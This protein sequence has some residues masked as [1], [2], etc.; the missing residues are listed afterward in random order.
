M[1]RFDQ[2]DDDERIGEDFGQVDGDRSRR[3][4]FEPRSAGQ[5]WLRNNGMPPWHMWG[6]TQ[7]QSVQPLGGASVPL[8][9]TSQQLCRINYGRPESWRW[10]FKAKLISGP[11]TTDVGQHGSLVVHWDLI[12]GVGRSMIQLLDFD[13]FSFAWDDGE[14]FPANREIWSTQTL[15]PAK[16]FVAPT[17]GAAATQVDNITAQDIQL[18]ARCTAQELSIVPNAPIVVELSAHFAPNAH[19]RPDWYRQGPE[20]IAFPGGEVEGR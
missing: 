10:L 14:A 1:V 8:I 16:T 18:I 17:P 11:D 15:S 2:D 5:P 4:E 7:L 6:N 13:R 20:E 12:L 3:A 19:I 9:A